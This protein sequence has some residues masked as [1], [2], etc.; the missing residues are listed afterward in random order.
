MRSMGPSKVPK[1]SPRDYLKKHRKPPDPPSR[2]I[3]TGLPSPGSSRFPIPPFFLPEG[4]RHV[5]GERK[6]QVPDGRSRLRLVRRKVDYVSD[7]IAER[8]QVDRSQPESVADSHRGHT[9]LAKD[10]GLFPQHVNKKVSSPPP[11]FEDRR[12]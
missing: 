7:A 4:E 10:S 2:H 11:P 3:W 12:R 5:C 1:P 8:R 6:P 9:Y